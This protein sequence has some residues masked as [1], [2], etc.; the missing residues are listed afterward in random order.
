[1]VLKQQANEPSWSASCVSPVLL[2]DP[3][4]YIFG[5]IAAECKTTQTRIHVLPTQA[6]LCDI[7]RVA[8]AHLPH[9][10]LTPGAAEHAGPNDV[11]AAT[12]LTFA[13][14]SFARATLQTE[15]EGFM[16]V[17]CGLREMY[18]AKIHGLREE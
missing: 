10:G 6:S 3:V 1:M 9:V 4:N 18:D 14:R 15:C 8:K 5:Q 2:L 13:E 12:E 7:A 11:A 17:M 16:T